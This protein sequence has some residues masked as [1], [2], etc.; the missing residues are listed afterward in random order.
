M[1][2]LLSLLLTV[3]LT[4]LVIFAARRLGWVAK[5]RADRWQS[6]P[7]ALMGGVAIF[8]GTIVSWLIYLPRSA[9]APVAI[10]ATAIFLLGFI[11]DRITLRP[12]IKLIGQVA[13]AGAVIIGGVRF[14][15]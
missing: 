12:H 6:K 4:P 9:Q 10:A 11:D 15:A 7:T 13:A 1:P 14:D 8:G 3:I 2:F 5:P